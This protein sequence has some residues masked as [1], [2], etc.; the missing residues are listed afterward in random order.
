MGIRRG[1]SL[2]RD[3]EKHRENVIRKYQRIEG[4]KDLIKA[5]EPLLHPSDPYL[6]HLSE[7]LRKEEVQFANMRP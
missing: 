4:L 3:W 6:K 5:W 1:E 7:R 2:G